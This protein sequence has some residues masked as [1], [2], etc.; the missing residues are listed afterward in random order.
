MMRFNR[1]ATTIIIYLLI[2]VLNILTFGEY[3]KATKLAGGEVGMIPIAMIIIFGITFLLSTIAFLII[4][5]KK[6]ISIITSIFI[7]HIIYLGVLISWGFDFKNLTN[8]KYTNVDLFIILIPFL[9][10]AIVSLVCKLWVS[11]WI[12]QNNQF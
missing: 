2:A 9:I 5:S 6:K 4:N 7:Y 12:E 10:W 3:L 11:K 1:T 8:L